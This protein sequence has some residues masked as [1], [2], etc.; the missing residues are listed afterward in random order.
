MF[1]TM[2]GFLKDIP[3]LPI[4]VNGPGTYE[5]PNGVLVT[6]A[7][8]CPYTYSPIL[9]EP[10]TDAPT[11]VNE[12]VGPGVFSRLDSIIWPDSVPFW[13][14]KPF[15]V[16]LLILAAVLLA[17]MFLFIALSRT[18]RRFSPE[19]RHHRKAV[20]E[21]AG[22]LPGNLLYQEAAK[23][24]N[25]NIL[26][27]R[28]SLV[29]KARRIHDDA[30]RKVNQEFQ[31]LVTDLREA[32]AERNWDMPEATRFYRRYSVPLSAL[33]DPQR[34]FRMFQMAELTY[35]RR[36]RVWCPK[37]V[38][39]RDSTDGMI[40]E[41]ECDPV[42]TLDCW[43]SA[44]GVLASALDA[45]DIDVTEPTG[46]HFALHLQDAGRRRGA[47]ENA[48]RIQGAL[49][50]YFGIP[51]DSP[52]DSAPGEP[53]ENQDYG[54]NQ[55]RELHVQEYTNPRT[56][57]PSYETYGLHPEVEELPEPAS[58]T[59]IPAEQKPTR[60]LRRGRRKRGSGDETGE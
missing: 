51:E 41:F 1:N 3:H 59:S 52:S 27:D 6:E 2:A 28:V 56:G 54:L 39:F 50:D 4:P 9:P 17:L 10:G 38:G 14:D 57:A 30:L 32:S 47:E 22:N 60:R 20:A 45:P 44:L 46:G 55:T 11:P 13:Q 33:T 37:L 40:V 42:L 48:D 49:A 35:E 31:A 18:T 34:M 26:A 43:V 25:R 29:T 36:G 16:H 21:V 15:W 12:P 7:A 58:V 5:C 24:V 53:P 19:R 8:E 23:E